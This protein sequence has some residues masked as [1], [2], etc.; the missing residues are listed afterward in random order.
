MR[1]GIF[2][3]NYLPLIN[4]L[5][6]SLERSIQHFRSQGHEVFVF[7]PRYPDSPWS[8]LPEDGV[9]RFPSLRAPTHSRYVLPLPVSAA[10]RRLLPT[11]ALDVVHAQH[12]FLLGPYARSVARRF[13]LPLVFTYHTLYEKYAHYVP[14][15]PSLGAWVARRRSVAFANSA[16]EVIVPTRGVAVALREWGVT[17]PLT[18]IPTG[19]DPEASS[20]RPVGL[21]ADRP[22][23][24]SVGR[25]APEKNLVFLLTA[26]RLLHR[27]RP[28]AL[29]VIVGDGE[30]RRALEALRDRWHLTDS[31]RFVGE[32]SPPEVAS[33]Y[34]ACHLFLFPSTSEVQG[35]VVLE[36]MAWGLPVVAVRS[37]AV[38]DFVE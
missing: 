16:D 37:L 22:L 33:Y 13:C 15:L 11:L 18:V 26:F 35:L 20:L 24:L 23:L 21:P 36:A 30:E 34:A 17:A 25:L 2:T 29:L 27:E 38:E 31:V 12:P 19:Y 3:C 14:L 8:P 5:S 10:V 32:V 7:A 9:Y 1:I 28:D 6:V 4:G